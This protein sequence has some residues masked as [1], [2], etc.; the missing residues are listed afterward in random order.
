MTDIIQKVKNLSIGFK[1][2][3]GEEILILKNIT[4]NIKKGETVGIVGESGSG[5]K[6]L[7]RIVEIIKEEVS[8]TLGLVGL[9]DINDVTSEIVID[10]TINKVNY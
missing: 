2:K 6:G 4:T 8:T 1:S 7:R 5:K 3:K 10:N 9:N